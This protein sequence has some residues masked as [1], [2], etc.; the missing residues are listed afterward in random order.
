VL[1][2]TCCVACDR[3]CTAEVFAKTGTATAMAGYELM[4]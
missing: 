4:A 3:V 1:S 2:V